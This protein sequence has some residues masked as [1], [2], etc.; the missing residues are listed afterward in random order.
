MTDSSNQKSVYNNSINETVP[1]FLVHAISCVVVFKFEVSPRDASRDR[2]LRPGGP[3]S[4]KAW[5]DPGKTS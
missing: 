1:R 4:G 5:V 2:V 3:L